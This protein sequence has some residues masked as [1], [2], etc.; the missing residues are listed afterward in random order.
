VPRCA[1][2]S[3]RLLAPLGG[4]TFL[5]DYLG[6]RPVHIEGGAEKFRELMS[7]SVLNRLL[8]MNTIWDAEGLV[9]VLDKEEV[10]PAAYLGRDQAA[11]GRPAADAAKVK[12][13]VKQGAT[14]SSTTS[15]SSRRSSAPS[16]G[17]WRRRWAARCRAISTSP[18]SAARGSGSITHP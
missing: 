17:R 1:W 4:E 15:T 10:P 2:A 7:W 3:T 6:K 13:Y 8:G 12:Q 14:W 5:R 16:P 11:S 9:M 18:R